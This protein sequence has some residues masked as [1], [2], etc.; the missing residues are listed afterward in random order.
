MK[1]GRLLDRASR[2]QGAVPQRSPAAVPRT[3]G[4]RTTNRAYASD[5]VG[6]GPEAHPTSDLQFRRPKCEHEV[7]QKMMPWHHLSMPRRNTARS[8]RN[9][10]ALFIRRTR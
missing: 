7:R 5:A 6:G 4:R 8:V 9:A 10:C 3:T 2:E 1:A